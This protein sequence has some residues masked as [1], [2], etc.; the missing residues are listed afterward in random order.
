MKRLSALIILALTF[1][2]ICAASSW[3]QE[4]GMPIPDFAD[5]SDKS[6][7]MQYAIQRLAVLG[8]V[9]GDEG[10]GSTFRPDDTLTRAEFAKIV[11]RLAGASSDQGLFSPTNNFRPQDTLTMQEAVTVFLRLAGF[12]DHL[13]AANTGAYGVWPGNYN[14]KAQ[15]LGLTA[16]VDNYEGSRAITRGELALLANYT[17]DMPT[18]VYIEDEKLPAE[19]RTL[20]RQNGHMDDYGFAQVWY[21]TSETQPEGGWMRSMLQKNF[22][23]RTVTVLFSELAVNED[24]QTVQYQYYDETS[25]ELVKRLVSRKISSQYYITQGLSAADLPGR[26]ARI[27][28]EID[29]IFIEILPD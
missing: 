29:I 15:E 12:N 23:I 27:T 6:Q 9:Q 17:L 10:L 28:F 20:A 24:A 7:H 16:Q 3:A 11:E 25:D 18:V 14:Q 2:L 21:V 1:T 26:H 19:T 13:G 8:I 4:P 5:I 22:G